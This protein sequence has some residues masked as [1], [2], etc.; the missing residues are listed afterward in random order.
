[1]WIDEDTGA[2]VDVN[3]LRE[4]DSVAFKEVNGAIEPELRAQMDK[5]LPDDRIPAYV[6]FGVDESGIPRKDEIVDMS[7]AE[8]LAVKDLFEARIASSA[9]ALLHAIK[10]RNAASK[11]SAIEVV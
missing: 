8:S 4:L 10:E 1:M 3:A 9:K 6:W 2:A 11:D 7:P 5:A